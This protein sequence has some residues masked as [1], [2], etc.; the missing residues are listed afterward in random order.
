M[1]DIGVRTVIIERVCLK[2]K[3][4]YDG[5]DDA[6]QRLC[7][8]HMRGTCGHASG[9]LPCYLDIGPG[10]CLYVHHETVIGKAF[11]SKIIDEL[12][13]QARGIVVDQ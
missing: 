7:A 3:M 6:H 9:A 12:W 10:R 1:V 2:S 8:R 11:S 13:S 4:W 5:G